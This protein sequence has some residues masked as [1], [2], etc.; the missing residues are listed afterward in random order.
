MEG[1]RCGVA[2]QDT[3]MQTEC[4]EKIDKNIEADLKPEVAEEEN[5]IMSEDEGICSE[6]SGGSTHESFDAKLNGGFI[7]EEYNSMEEMCTE[8][9]KPLKLQ[10]AE[11]EGDYIELKSITEEMKKKDARINILTALNEAL[12][13]DIKEIETKNSE[14]Q[15]IAEI[16]IKLNELLLNVTEISEKTLQLNNQ[17]QQEEK[18]ELGK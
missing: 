6:V 13:Q 9:D 5:K 10:L 2:F 16:Y 7:D 11:V 12:K 3:A 17:E 14:Q 18:K 8:D 15:Q 4:G 1:F